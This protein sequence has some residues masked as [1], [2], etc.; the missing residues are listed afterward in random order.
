MG[1]KPNRYMVPYSK[2]NGYVKEGRDGGRYGMGAPQDVQG[3]DCSD[4]PNG[5]AAAP[6]VWDY[7]GT[8]FKL[9]FKAGFAGAQYEEDS[10]IVRPLVG[11]FIAHDGDDERA[12]KGGKGHGR[13]GRG[14][15][16][17]FGA[18]ERA[19]KG[20]KVMHLLPIVQ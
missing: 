18:D 7:N 11:W 5:L 19:S 8:E 9:K 4:F 3:P 6:V 2:D 15:A 14:A 20:G 12:S 1:D 10:K 16:M 13:R 17:N